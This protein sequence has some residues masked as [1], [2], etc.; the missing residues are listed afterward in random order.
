MP[1]SI[2]NSLEM[3]L[4]MSLRGRSVKLFTG[5]GAALYVEI[6]AS[7]TPEASSG[8]SASQLFLVIYVCASDESI[9]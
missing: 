6:A 5:A 7:V 8:S 3:D 4:D 2:E 9:L 1:D